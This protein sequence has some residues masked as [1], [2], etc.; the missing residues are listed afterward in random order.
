MR[1]NS[2]VLW[3]SK[4][5]AAFGGGAFISLGHELAHTLDRFSGTMDMGTWFVTPEG[6]KYQMQKTFQLL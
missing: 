3:N 4:K 1:Y 2:R 6:K 5:D